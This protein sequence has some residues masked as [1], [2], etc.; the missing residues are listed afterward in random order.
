MSGERQP[1][2]AKPC[3]WWHCWLPFA[4]VFN[5]MPRSSQCAACGRIIDVR[6]N[7]Q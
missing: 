3:P 4:Y 2:T 5:E 6:E 7:H 1:K